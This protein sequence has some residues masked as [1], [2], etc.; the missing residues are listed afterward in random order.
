MDLPIL[1]SIILVIF[2]L[3]Y[4]FRE[5]FIVDTTY[6]NTPNLKGVFLTRP[7]VSMPVP[8]PPMYI[9]YLSSPASRVGIPDTGRVMFGPM[10]TSVPN[11]PAGRWVIVGYGYPE[12]DPNGR[13]INVYQLKYPQRD[14][15]TYG[16]RYRKEGVFVP[17]DMPNNDRIRN[18]DKFTIKGKGAYHF[19]ETNRNRLVWF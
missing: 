5:S 9:P 7:Y 13:L 17:F 6:V 18:G 12:H 15:Y 11:E 10:L 2:I 1:A 16:V 3:L 19:V 8:M 14:I 4:F